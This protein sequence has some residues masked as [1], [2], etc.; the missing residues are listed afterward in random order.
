[1]VTSLGEMVGV[2]LIIGTD[3]DRADVKVTGRS[4][5]IDD[6]CLDPDVVEDCPHE[7]STLR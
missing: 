1:M 2:M 7:L 3:M 5:V 6:T 4:P